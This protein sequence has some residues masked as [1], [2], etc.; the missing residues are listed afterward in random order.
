MSSSPALLTI[1]SQAE[2]LNGVTNTSAIANVYIGKTI[3]HQVIIFRGYHVVSDPANLPAAPN[4]YMIYVD[5]PWLGAAN[6]V[7][8]LSYQ[9]RLPLPIDV[10]ETSLTATLHS[11]LK[12][13]MTMPLQLVSDIPQQFTMAVYNRDG[14][15]VSTSWIKSVSLTFSYGSTTTAG[16]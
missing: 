4:G 6:L 10:D 14:S 5:V 2:T 3:P 1:T 7:D 16:F 13:E 15:P 12:W 9:N 8:G 11:T